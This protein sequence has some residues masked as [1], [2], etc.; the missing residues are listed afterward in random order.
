MAASGA[1]HTPFMSYFMYILA[2]KPRGT[3]Y[4]G[5]TN[6]LARRVY[7]HKSKVGCRFT[8]KYGVSKLVS[9]EQ[10]RD[11]ND[12]IRREKQVKRWRRDWKVD[13]IEGFNPKWDDLYLR[14]NH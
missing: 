13:A 6:D 7:E 8:A 12:A 2:S 10:F 4:T 14:F 3:P 9:F 11:V 5:V 1:G